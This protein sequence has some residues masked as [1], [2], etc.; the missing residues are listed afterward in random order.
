MRYVI[1][2]PSGGYYSDNEITGTRDCIE[3][4]GTGNKTVHARPLI[5]PKFDGRTPN[6][7]CKFHE[8]QAATDM[9]TNEFLADP[10]AFAG[11]EVVEF[12]FD[13]Y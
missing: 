7:A 3:K 13:A 9:L 2:G 8:Q 12:P 6:D 10:A 4:D 1:K 11:A 5:S